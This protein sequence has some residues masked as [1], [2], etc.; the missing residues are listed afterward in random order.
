MIS[1]EIDRNQYSSSVAAPSCW[2]SMLNQWIS[3]Y[4][5]FNVTFHHEG[6]TNMWYIPRA[7]LCMKYGEG[8]IVSLSELF[9]ASVPVE[10]CCEEFEVFVLFIHP[11]SSQGWTV[12]MI[13]NKQIVIA[14]NLAGEQETLIT[15]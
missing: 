8:P 7:R 1:K 12:K 5:I 6:R 2:Y 11:T 3:F 4:V 10:F 9:P 14:A 13:P 15:Y